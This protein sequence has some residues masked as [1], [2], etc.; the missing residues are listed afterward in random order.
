MKKTMPFFLLAAVFAAPTAQAAQWTPIGN[1]SKDS[2]R[3]E[4]DSA[5]LHTPTE[6]RVR[7]PG[8][9]KPTRPL[10]YPIRAFFLHAADDAQRI[11]V[12]QAPTC[13]I[14]ANV[15]PRR[16][17]RTENR[18]FRRA[19]D[20]T[21]DARLPRR[22]PFQPRLQVAQQACCR[23]TAAASAAPYRRRTGRNNQKEKMAKA[24]RGSSPPPPPSH[25]GYSGNS[26]P[27]KWGRSTR[28][29]PPAVSASASRRSTSARRSRPISLAI[30]FAYKSN[31]S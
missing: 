17:H 6:G 21:G 12:R 20:T 22:N 29:T 25:W 28:I 14:A 15:C 5:S 11:S 31:K 4:I 8:T 23:H 19:R 10:D 9:A 13:H 16:R 2:G 30:Q 26:G 7:L 3:V 27:D 18:N 1:G 24:G